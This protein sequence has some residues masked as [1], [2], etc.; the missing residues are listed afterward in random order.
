[1]P[2]TDLWLGDHF[3]WISSAKLKTS[4]KPNDTLR[5]VWQQVAL[6]LSCLASWLGKIPKQANSTRQCTPCHTCDNQL[7]GGEGAA[8]PPPPRGVEKYQSY[9]ALIPDTSGREAPALHWT[10][11]HFA[12]N[13]FLGNSQLFKQRLSAHKFSLHKFQITTGKLSW[14]NFVSSNQA[15]A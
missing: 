9:K 12:Y 5:K 2:A 10:E 8:R 15:L 11:S 14:D 3:T 1:M 13:S 4:H 6:K 7:S